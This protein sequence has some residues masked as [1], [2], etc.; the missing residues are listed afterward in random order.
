MCCCASV[1]TAYVHQRLR[2][3]EFQRWGVA[4]QFINQPDLEDTPQNRLLLG[5]QGLF[6]EYER[7]VIRDRLRRG[8]LHRIRQGGRCFHPA[9]FGYGYIP[10]SEPN[11]G[12]W[13][14]NSQEA[15]VVQQIFAWYTEE[16]WSLRKI[17][18]QLNDTGVPVRHK[19]GRWQANRISTI[20]DKHAYAGKT[21][22]NQYRTRPESVGRLKKLGR[23]RLVT[24]DSVIR[25]PEEW[26]A[27]D[28]PAILSKEVWQRAQEQRMHNQRFSQRNNHKQFYLLCG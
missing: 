27:V 5:V 11:G 14:I 4:V 19:G 13:E 26:I 24:P 9:P 7:E 23:G 6:A 12:R 17:A 18:T 28:T 2:L 21:Y 22:Y 25:P 20:L 8:R 1:L 10:V 3:D 16:C 15:A